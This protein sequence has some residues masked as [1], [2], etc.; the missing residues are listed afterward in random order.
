VFHLSFLIGHFCDILKIT[1]PIYVL[2]T[3][4]LLWILRVNKKLV[5]LATMFILT[6]A[7]QR[8][9]NLGA[10]EGRRR[11]GSWLLAEVMTVS[12]SFLHI[13]PTLVDLARGRPAGPGG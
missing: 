1:N 10:R 6:L 9:V 4:S 2:K 8:E 5:Y 7:L 11:K 3:F 13:L 12:I